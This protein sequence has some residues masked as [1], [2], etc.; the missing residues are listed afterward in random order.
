MGYTYAFL[1]KKRRKRREVLS[2]HQTTVM[3]SLED[4][5]C[6]VDLFLSHKF[7]AYSRSFFSSL[8]EKGLVSLNGKIVKKRE[9]PAP[10]DALSFYVEKKAPPETM[11]QDIS[12]EIIYEDDDILAINK[13][14]NFVV[15]PAPGHKDGTLVNALIHRNHQLK[16]LQDIRYGL[17][18]RLDKDTS[19]VMVIAKHLKSHELLSASFKQRLIKKTYLALCI[20]RP[21]DGLIHNQLGRCPKNRKKYTVVD[22]GREAISEI[23]VLEFKHGFSLVEINPHTGRTHQI[24][25]HLS[26]LGCPIVGDPLY[27]ST[28]V[29]KEV[30]FSGQFLHAKSLC[31]SHPFKKAPLDLEAPIPET[32]LKIKK[33]LFKEK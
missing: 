8:I 32:F 15:H 30:G 33:T 22:E 26:H 25:V 6:R 20:G 28:K 27:G 2:V 21:K 3:V 17:V 12:L 11:A 19:G 24:R 29:N 16:E 31:L 14:Q 5:L 23:K 9:I 4:A 18:H 1:H 13:P 7:P 10:G